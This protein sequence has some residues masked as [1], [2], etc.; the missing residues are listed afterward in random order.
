MKRLFVYF[1]GIGD[2]VMFVPLLRRFAEDGPTD[3]LVRDFATGMLDGQLFVRR[4]WTLRHPNRGRS[5]A[6]ALLFGGERRNLGRGLA[7]EAY[8]EIV[9]FDR[10][11]QHI[12][13]WIESWCGAGI[14]R[15][16]KLS[17]G[18]PDR[19][20]VSCM[21]LGIDPDSME[22]WP[23]ME[24][25]QHLRSRMADLLTPMGRV[26]GVQVGS[27]PVSKWPRRF[28]VKGLSPEQWAG[29][30]TR[31]LESGEADAVVFQGT[32]DE[33]PLVDAVINGLG[34][35]VR[36]RSHDWTGR[37]EL[38]E[39]MAL[40]VCY[41][42][43]VSV[44]TGPAHLA[45]AVGCPL[46]VFF[47]PSDPREYLMRGSAP[48]SMVLGSAPCQFCAGTDAF[49]RCRH[50][51]CLRDLGVDDLWRAWLRLVG[52]MGQR[53]LLQRDAQVS[54]RKTDAAMGD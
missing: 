30:V 28:D 52:E 32:R 33:R 46:L 35:S 7:Q 11:R 38:K 3:V 13:R 39:L 12:V 5:A 4:V 47:G 37:F 44:D 43:L 25:D 1:A 54:L 51:R 2:A 27:G 10:E 29:L 9:I 49:K 34:S 15:R 45:A 16:A 17:S 42:A 26:V 14:V 8:D 19:L 31:L 21:S 24:V 48:V 22:P 41:R 18:H 36:S 50:N 6:A 40:M 53:E 23:R 20:G